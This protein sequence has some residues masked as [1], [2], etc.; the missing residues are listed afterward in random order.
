MTEVNEIT[1]NVIAVKPKV[2]I[3]AKD[4]TVH[5]LISVEDETYLDNMISDIKNYMQTSTVT[6][7]SDE[8]I[9]DYEYSTLK[10]MWNQASG[11][12]VGRL[13]SVNFK[14]PLYRE[15]YKY[16]TELLLTKMEYNIDTVFYAV[17]L[18]DALA[19]MEG[20]KYKDDKE[21]KL[22]DFTSVDLTYIY[23][24]LAKHTMK[25]LTKGTYS[26]VSIIKA[27]ISV[28]KVFDYYKNEYELLVKD[29]QEWATV[30]SQD[31]QTADMQQ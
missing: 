19:N 22:F 20:A 13:N 8:S 29:I 15:D 7:D 23:H 4:G 12:N 10:N 27:I 21:I 17:E 25:G 28:S 1:E 24:L 30:F 2:E 18:T 5:R 16:L 11:R 14:L 6:I 26:Y 31:T 3:T 9:K